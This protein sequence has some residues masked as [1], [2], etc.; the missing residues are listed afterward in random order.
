MATSSNIASF[1]SKFPVHGVTTSTALNDLKNLCGYDV[2]YKNFY[3]Q[4]V[5]FTTPNYTG[6][7]TS[8]S[9][10]ISMSPYQSINYGS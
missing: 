9:V 5:P 10:K 2:T 8:I 7:I 4:G 3:A 1:S 6:T